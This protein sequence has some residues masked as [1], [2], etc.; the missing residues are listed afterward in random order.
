VIT[1]RAAV[2]FDPVDGEFA[3]LGMQNLLEPID[4]ARPGAA[5]DWRVTIEE[6][7][8]L[9]ADPV[10]CRGDH[11]TRSGASYADHLSL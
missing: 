3:R 11:L 4:P 10:P 8:A 7:E 5:L 9:E 6:W 2:D 1:E